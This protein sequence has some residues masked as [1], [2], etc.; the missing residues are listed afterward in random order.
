MYSL[1][2][3][4]EEGGFVAKLLL[5]VI[6]LGFIG[7]G[8][9]DSVLGAAW[10]VM[11]SDLGVNVDVLGIITAVSCV[12]GI[13]SS[14]MSA[15][16]IS[17]FGVGKVTFVSTLLTALGL[18]LYSISGSF[19]FLCLVTVPSGIG[20]G[21]I[22]AGLNNYVA[23][24]YSASHM[25]FLHCFYGVG[26]MVSPVFMAIALK[27]DGSWRNG[28]RYVFIIQLFIALVMLIAI[29]MWNKAH[30]ETTPEPAEKK[31][32]IL[33]GKELVKLKNFKAVLFIF[34]AACSVE[35]TLGAW[36]GTFLNSAKGFSPSAAAG[37]VT[38]FFAGLALGRF[39]SGVLSSKLS[40]MKIIFTGLSFV[41]AGLALMLLP[42]SVTALGGLF[43][44]GFGI[45]PVYPNIMH[46]T[47]KIFGEENSQSVMGTQQAA[48]YCGVL[49]MPALFGAVAGN[50]GA[51]LLPVYTF[52][53]LFITAI[54]AFAIRKGIKHRQDGF[55]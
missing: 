19:F 17:R 1:V 41:A 21:A 44:G 2:V 28:Y 30:G 43:L 39:L 15:R 4:K 36:G 45:G 3:G 7:L 24:H 10:P 22:D 8:L 38:L 47:P 49:F 40:S 9:P 16:L 23:L 18:L 35:C 37:G 25:S 27:G 13:I 26:V 54:S 55:K 31:T 14:L 12:C 34:F 51:Y 42:F 48:A 6:Y 53:L 11:H 46:L 50:I 20:A 33:T 29:P 52:L 5:I 32:K